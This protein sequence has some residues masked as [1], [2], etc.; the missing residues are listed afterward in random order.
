MHKTT[1][2]SIIEHLI[3]YEA[4]SKEKNESYFITEDIQLKKINY[5][6]IKTNFYK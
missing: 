5:L 3:F 4:E 1:L 6:K 2:L